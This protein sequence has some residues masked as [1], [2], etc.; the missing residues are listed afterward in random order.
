MNKQRGFTFIELLLLAAI[1]VLGSAILYRALHTEEARVS[2][3]VQGLYTVPLQEV[4]I[5]C[6]QG[7]AKNQCI[8]EYTDPKN[9]G[10]TVTTTVTCGILR[11]EPLF[12][13][14]N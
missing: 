6:N 2:K 3:Y 10:N 4:R 5:T 12:G 8:A 9:G 1:G 11:C 14:A 13:N 7:T